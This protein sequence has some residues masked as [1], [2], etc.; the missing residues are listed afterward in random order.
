MSMGLFYASL[1]SCLTIIIK[2][3]FIYFSLIINQITI[4]VSINNL[5]LFLFN[6]ILLI[7]FTWGVHQVRVKEA[8]IVFTSIAILK[9]KKN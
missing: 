6:I 1:L 8:A 4:T 9:S 7:I 2:T 3:I 5:S